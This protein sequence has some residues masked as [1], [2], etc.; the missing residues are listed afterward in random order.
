MRVPALGACGFVGANLIE[1]L[2]DAGNKVVAT[3]RSRVEQPGIFHVASPELGLEADW[4][5]ALVD[6]DA[7]L[8][9]DGEDVSTAELIEKIARANGS[10]QCPV[11]QFQAKRPFTRHSVGRRGDLFAS[12]LSRS[13]FR[14]RRS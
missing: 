13:V 11:I 7:V 8:P 2:Q 1:V 9:S 12:R 6:I 3:S 5:E 10:V 14:Q 4:S